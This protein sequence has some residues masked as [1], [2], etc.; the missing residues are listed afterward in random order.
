M[1]VAGWK[2][3]G[4]DEKKYRFKPGKK[5]KKSVPPGASKSGSFFFVFF[6]VHGVC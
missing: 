6:L 1:S 3:K 2:F 4:F 5:F